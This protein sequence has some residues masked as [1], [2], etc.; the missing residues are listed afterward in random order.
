MVLVQMM[1]QTEAAHD[2]VEQIGHLGC[3]EFVDVN[4]LIILVK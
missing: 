3:V 2:S 4:N 1:L